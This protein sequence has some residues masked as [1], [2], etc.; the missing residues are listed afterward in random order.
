METFGE[1]NRVQLMWLRA[2]EIN[3]VLEAVP[4]KEGN[5]LTR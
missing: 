2:E 5:F 3:A 1:K 4:K